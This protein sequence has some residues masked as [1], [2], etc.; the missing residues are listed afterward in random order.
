MAETIADKILYTT[1]KVSTFSGVD[2]IG[3]GTGFFWRTRIDGDKEIISLVTNRHV[4]AGADRIKVTCHISAGALVQKPSGAFTKLEVVLVERDTIYHPDPNVD[5]LAIPFVSMLQT[6]RE[7]GVP[8][9]Y[10]ALQAD[11]LPPAHAWAEFDS[12]ED[13]IMVGCPRGIFDE[14]NNMPIARRGITATALGKRYEGRDEFL[15]DMACFPGSSGSPVFLHNQHGFFSRA[16]NRY[17][18]GHERFYFVGILYA[19]PT[20]THEGEI[21]MNRAPSVEVATTMHLGQVIRSSAL[22]ALDETLRH[23]CTRPG[24]P[25]YTFS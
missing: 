20:F 15:V 10:V 11:T 4:L 23:L 13:V 3:S 22:E 12:I 8:V 14:A 18:I 5:L 6:A 16:D 24:I 25:H 17:Q 21:V 9:H 2:S 1:V 19:G 7:Q